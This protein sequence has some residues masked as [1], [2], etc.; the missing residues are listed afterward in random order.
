M[1]ILA[2]D[3]AYIYDEKDNLIKKIT[4]NKTDKFEVIDEYTYDIHGNM[5]YNSTF[6]NGVLVFEN[7]CAYDEDHNLVTEEFFEINFWEKR[8]TRHE[9][10]IHEW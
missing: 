7:R 2:E 5:V 8:I 3:I 4:T 6:Q 1:P 9:R 10:L